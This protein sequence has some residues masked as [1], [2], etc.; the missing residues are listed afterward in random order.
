MRL[1]A[2]P[3]LHCVPSINDCKHAMPTMKTAGTACIAALCVGA[4]L[5]V[6]G[7]DS[8]MT[9]NFKSGIVYATGTL[10]LGLFSPGYKEYA[11]GSFGGGKVPRI[12]ALAYR[13]TPYAN[14]R[15]V[16]KVEVCFRSWQQVNFSK[17]A[18]VTDRR[19]D[20]IKDFNQVDF[21]YGCSF[22]I[23][24]TLFGG[25]YPALRP[26][27]GDVITIAYEYGD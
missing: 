4:A 7:A 18:D 12:T 11:K 27:A 3:K 5:P 9:G 2:S 14:G 6:Q 19:S 15:L 13:W 20:V 26:E 25:R 16:E 8:T 1:P 10:S 21:K 23:R 17:C 24:H 22:A